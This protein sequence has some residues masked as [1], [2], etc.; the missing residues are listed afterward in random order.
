M[1][2]LPLVKPNV[3]DLSRKKFRASSGPCS[4]FRRHP[5]GAGSAHNAQT[6]TKFYRREIAETSAK[7][8]TNKAQI[9]YRIC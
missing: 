1:Q 3:S 7:I 9:K 6:H 2:L 8:Q 4:K 5:R